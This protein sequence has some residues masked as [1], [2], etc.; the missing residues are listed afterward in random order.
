MPP[1]TDILPDLS[2]IPQL[3]G[4]PHDHQEQQAL[5]P[6]Q[7]HVV[8]RPSSSTGVDYMNRFSRP[9]LHARKTSFS[10]DKNKQLKKLRKDASLADFEIEVSPNNENVNIQC[11]TGFYT[12]VAKPALEDLA[13][14][15][16]SSVGN[17]IVKCHDIT[18]RTDVSGAATTTVIMYRLFQQKLS[19]GQ[20]T[21]HLHHTSRNVQVQ[22]SAL[23]PDNTKAPVWFVENVLRNR[24]NEMSRTQAYDISMFNKSVGEMVTKHLEQVNT[25]TACDGCQVNFNGRSSPEQCPDCKLYFHKFKCYQSSNHPCHVKKRTMSFTN[26]RETQCLVRKNDSHFPGAQYPHTAE[27]T[28]TLPTPGHPTQSSAMLNQVSGQSNPTPTMVSSEAT[29]SHQSSIP[30][31][32]PSPPS[33]CQPPLQVTPTTESTNMTLLPPA[34]LV[35]APSLSSRASPLSPPTAGTSST[36]GTSN[37][38][39]PNVP[40]FVSTLD[41]QNAHSSNR[42][43]VK[44]KGKGKKSKT[45]CDLPL[46]YAKY[47]VNITQAKIRDQE[48]TIKDL[49]FRNSLLE[50]RVAELEKKQKEDIYERYFP[51]P[52]VKRTQEST[53]QAERRSC[54]SGPPHLVPSCCRNQQFACQHQ[55][56]SD[57]SNEPALGSAVNDA[58]KAIEVLSKDVSALKCKVDILADLSIPQ[59]LREYL[60]KQ[61]HAPPP[62]DNSNGPSATKLPPQTAS[63]TTQHYQDL[64]NASHTTIDDAVHDISG[65]LN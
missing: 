18:L 33:T 14:G 21:V 46:E 39:N 42:D 28:A 20:V 25:R 53:S 34:S 6:S 40:P 13:V 51:K 27:Q 63:D 2:P 26:K 57:T 59:M 11:S 50:S 17:V 19:I 52:D 30:R 62:T 43:E 23:L 16:S 49:R 4:H 32:I 29:L 44:N 31:P 15:T 41:N 56:V 58:I 60:Q 7:D 12:K 38:L 65:E 61:N 36:T 45:V 9:S 24:F 5:P 22:G 64:L 3:D 10:L 37:S 35:L 47:E 48:V 54:C 1:I 8:V 55:H